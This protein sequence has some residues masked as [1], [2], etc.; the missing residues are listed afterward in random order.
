VHRGRPLLLAPGP[1]LVARDCI[2]GEPDDAR[3][4][5]VVGPELYGRRIGEMLLEL[6]DV[7]DPRAAEAVDAL[8]V[9]PDAEYVRAILG[10][11]A[12]HEF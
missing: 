8:R 11:E 5:A 2:F 1:A 3:S 6:P 9:V 7:L 4:G 10:H 12:A